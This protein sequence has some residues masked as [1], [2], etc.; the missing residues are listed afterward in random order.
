MHIYKITFI[1]NKIDSC[2]ISTNTEME[3]SYTYQQHNGRM[4]YVLIK[5]DNEIQA[6]EKATELAHQITT[7]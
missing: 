6:K 1:D 2:K 4:I 7:G 5:A 3:G